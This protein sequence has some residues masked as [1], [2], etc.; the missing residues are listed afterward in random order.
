[1]IDLPAARTFVAAHGR[2][3]DRS[4]FAMLADGEPAEPVIRS[5]AAYA[6][7]DGGFG[8]AL[9][10]DVRATGSQP[11]AVLAA[12]DV[13]HEAGAGDH[14][15]ALAALDWLVTV[16]NPD[17]GV[18]FLLPDADSAPHAPFLVPDA[19]GS[20]S[21]HMT[22]AVTAAALRLSDAAR[23]HPWV[24]AATAFCWAHMPGEG[25][26]AFELKYA[27]EFLDAVPDAERAT[28]ALE[29]LRPLIPPDRGLPVR[30]G[31][32][33]EELGLE[34]LT[35]SPG[36]SRALFDAAAVERAL[37]AHAA[38]QHEDGGWDFDWLRW[39]PAV[40]WEWRGRLT[41]DALALL[42]ANDRLPAAR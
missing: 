36:R 22:S 28:A 25:A 5:L 23:A 26:F 40:A 32:P 9:E 2:L 11:I 33:G 38:A 6:N 14:P 20:S 13:L 10:P 30:G 27:L 1:M 17:G 7:D 15:L 18:P 41:V 29:A 35:P 8:R 3:L 24:A 16:T 37:D 19:T 39:N 31:V 4:R 34:V 12:F 42:V 21:F